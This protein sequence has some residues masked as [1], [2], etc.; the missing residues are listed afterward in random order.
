MPTRAAGSARTTF[1]L[2]TPRNPDTSESP[3]GAGQARPVLPTGAASGNLPAGPAPASASGDFENTPSPSTSPSQRRNIGGIFSLARFGMGLGARALSRTR[4]SPRS[5]PTRSGGSGN[6]AVKAAKLDTSQGGHWQGATSSTRTPPTF[7]FPT[8]H[9]QSPHRRGGD[10]TSNTAE[11]LEDATIL[12]V[13]QPARNSD[14]SR[15]PSRNRLGAVTGGDVQIVEFRNPMLANVRSALANDS[16][17][18][19]HQ[20]RSSVTSVS[21]RR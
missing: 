17:V 15:P 21:E 19:T 10:S 18:D 14:S 7:K 12:H 2:T 8:S 9:W 1:K 3:P 13:P 4:T 16:D 20:S 5:N 11:Q 6:G